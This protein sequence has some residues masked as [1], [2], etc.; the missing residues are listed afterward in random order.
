MQRIP[1]ESEGAWG[2]CLALYKGSVEL[3]V[4]PLSGCPRLS[5]GRMLFISRP[6]I[7]AAGEKITDAL[8]TEEPLAPDR[9]WPADTDGANFALGC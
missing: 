5:C 8:A 3:L 4:F 7:H 6:V 1:R 9:P 2:V